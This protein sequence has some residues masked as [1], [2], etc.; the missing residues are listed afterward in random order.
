MGAIN[1]DQPS[2]GN[3]TSTEAALKVFN[4]NGSA[5]VANSFQEG[6]EGI[7][8]LGSTGVHA[9]TQ[10]QNGSGVLGQHFGGDGLAGVGVIGTAEGPNG[11]IAGEGVLGEG[12]NGVH[13][14]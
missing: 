5:I 12:R 9:E 8:A 13:G 3:V 1:F 14:R 7:L 6:G 10:N 11:E 2:S 4:S